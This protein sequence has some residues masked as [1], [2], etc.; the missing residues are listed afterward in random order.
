MSIKP[1]LPHAHRLLAEVFKAMGKEK[2]VLEQEVLHDE[3]RGKLE[4]AV[5]FF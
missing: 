1:Q 4:V 5:V 3:T 2:E